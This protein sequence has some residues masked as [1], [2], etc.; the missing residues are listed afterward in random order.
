MK[1]EHVYLHDHQT[2]AEATMGLGRYLDFYNRERPHQ[3]LGYRTPS[4][5]Y[6]A[7]APLVE[8]GGI[9]CKN[10]AAVAP[11]ALRAPY[12]TAASP[13]ERSP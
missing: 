4:E 10:P 2:V 1:H 12:A 13:P 3:A 9:R 5:V 8:V 6:G 11:V 7:A